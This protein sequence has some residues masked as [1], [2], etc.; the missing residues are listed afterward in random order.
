LEI[1]ARVGTRGFKWRKLVPF[2]GIHAAGPDEGALAVL[3][4]EH[5]GTAFRPSVWLAYRRR[6]FVSP[7]GLARVALDR[8]IVLRWAAPALAPRRPPGPLPF[9]VIEV[10][11]PR[12]EPPAWLSTA[13][14]R[15]ARSTAFSKY[16]LCVEHARGGFC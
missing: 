16:G 1:K 5:L 7:D 3:L 2:A 12:P 13:I 8:D 11:G 4:R 14:G 6:R 15:F 10:K 9:F